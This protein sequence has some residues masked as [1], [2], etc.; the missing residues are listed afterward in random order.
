MKKYFLHESSKWCDE[1]AGK[2][3]AHAKNN[4]VFNIPVYALM[5]TCVLVNLVR[6]TAKEYLFSFSNFKIKQSI[7]NY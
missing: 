1:A 5:T 2:I 7:C 6:F 3:T 4:T